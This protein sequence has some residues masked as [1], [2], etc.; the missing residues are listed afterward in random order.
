MCR[1]PF[2]L[3]RDLPA[4]LRAVRHA[5]TLYQDRKHEISPTRH[6]VDVFFPPLTTDVMTQVCTRWQ[7]QTGYLSE[8][9]VWE[10]HED[11]RGFL[12]PN[13][14]Q[15][16][17]FKGI[18]DRHTLW[19]DLICGDCFSLPDSTN[20]SFVDLTRGPGIGIFLVYYPLGSCYW[21]QFSPLQIKSMK[22]GIFQSLFYLTKISVGIT[23][24]YSQSKGA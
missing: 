11:R 19:K 6:N 9:T 18:I 17:A 1:F 4:A 7:L 13:M 16:L 15:F 10:G 12:F 22:K 8:T 23:C 21:Y 3:F 20:A 2:Q 5:W 14:W 24:F